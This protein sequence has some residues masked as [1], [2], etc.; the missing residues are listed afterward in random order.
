MTRRL[1]VSPRYCV[2]SVT[3]FYTCKHLKP[4]REMDYLATL[5]ACQKAIEREGL[6]YF[7]KQP[8]KL[9]SVHYNENTVEGHSVAVTF[10]AMNCMKTLTAEYLYS[11]NPGLALF[12]QIGVLK[13][14]SVVEVPRNLMTPQIEAKTLVTLVQQSFVPA[15]EL[16][17]DQTLCRDKNDIEKILDDEWEKY[18][19]S[20][21]FYVKKLGIDPRLLKSC[22]ERLIKLEIL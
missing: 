18:G 1:T 7:K 12:N 16:Q 5:K 20:F 21:E 10:H 17:V 22:Q 6:D 3:L 14:I 8:K 11:A 2:K 4:K 19:D 9:V 13:G 15:N